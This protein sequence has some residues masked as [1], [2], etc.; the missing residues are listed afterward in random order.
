[1]YNEGG[2]MKR[3]EV[4]GIIKGQLMK[5]Y[6]KFNDFDCK[7]GGSFIVNYSII[8]SPQKFIEKPI[9]FPRNS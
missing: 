4:D 7:G 3:M 1:M 9:K 8:R 6:T 5:Y 2:N